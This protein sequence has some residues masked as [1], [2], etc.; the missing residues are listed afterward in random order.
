MTDTEMRIK[1]YILD[2]CLPGENPA[3]LTEDTPLITGGILDS[4]STMKLVMFL[5]EE[6]GV[7]IEAHEMSPDHLNTIARV[8]RTV[9]SKRQPT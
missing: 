4:I 9:E 2:E 1:Q 3:L 5:E 7:S 6:F 8:A